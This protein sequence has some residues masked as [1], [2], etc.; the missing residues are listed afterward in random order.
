MKNDCVF[1]QVFGRNKEVLIEF[2][3]SILESCNLIKK[4]K[5]KKI[6]DLTICNELSLEKITKESKGCRLDI[7]ATYKNNIFN[8]EMQVV[9]DKFMIDRVI[10]YGGILKGE[11]IDV[12]ETYD[13]VKNVISIVI[14][15][16]NLYDNRASIL[17]SSKL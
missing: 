3:N 8:I 1:Q 6:E 16:F 9:T 4:D 5:L 11:S 10:T 12:G 14:A 17:Y 13:K 7:K 15:D 2:L